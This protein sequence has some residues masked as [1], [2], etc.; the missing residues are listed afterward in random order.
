MSNASAVIG[1]SSAGLIETPAFKIP[2][3]NIGRRQKNR[4]KAKNVINIEKYSD[5]KL[6]NAVKKI[7]SKKF[8]K[9]V[10]SVKNPYGNGTS[11][12][13]IIEVI[14]KT[15]IDDKLLKKQLTF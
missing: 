2:T 11:S 3:I 5:Q 6:L 4:V 15:K 14:K 8:K 12:K 9:M 13:K 1:N 7:F 10:S